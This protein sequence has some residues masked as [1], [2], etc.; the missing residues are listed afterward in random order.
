[1]QG[2]VIQHSQHLRRCH[3]C[4][5]TLVACLLFA[6]HA[7]AQDNKTE[8]W[9][10]AAGAGPGKI[11]VVD[12]YQEKWQK[13]KNNFSFDVALE[14][15]SLPEDS[16][17]FD[18]DYG[19]PVISA[20]MKVALNHNVTMHKSQDKHW[21]LAQP[22][23]YDSRMGNVVALYGTFARPFFRNKFFEADAAIST[24]LGYSNTIYDKDNNVDDELIGSHFLIYLGAHLT[25]RFMPVWG[26]WAG[27]DYW[28][29]SNGTLGRPNKGAN[30][31]GPT[32]GLAYMPHFEHV[33]TMGMKRSFNP[34]EKKWYVELT[35]GVGART[36]Y[37]E[38]DQTQ[39]KTPMGEEDYRTGDFKLYIAYS[40]Q[41]DL[42][43]RYDRKWA[44][45]VGLD[46][47][48]GGYASTVEKIEQKRGVDAEHSPWSVGLAFK[49][50]A[51]YKQLSLAMSFGWYLYREMGENAKVMEKRYYERIGLKYTLPG[52]RHLSIGASVKAHSTKADL[53]EIHLSLPISLQH[54]SKD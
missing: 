49:H 41:A 39:Y 38:W 20:R 47:F 9:G 37:E 1:M 48:Y 14:H 2:M 53:T 36:L 24:G 31:V 34:F 46:L 29:L 15:R 50:Q 5:A 25:W 11:I 44:S 13:G 8:R 3:A 12:K 51:F 40:A 23:D 22:V 19:L 33:R 4:T 42:M 17:D 54:K 32:I 52:K 35:A 7:E 30:F 45:G 18:Q 43:C 28:H 27:G 10:V 21:G 6:I 16:S 26:L